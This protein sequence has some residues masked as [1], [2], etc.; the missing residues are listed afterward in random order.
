MTPGFSR[1]ISLPLSPSRKKPSHVRSASLPCRSH[2]LVSHLEDEIRAVRSWL[3]HP[4][5]DPGSPAGIQAGLAQIQYLHAALDDLLHLPRAQDPL[6]RAAG[7]D[8][9]LD[10][11]LRLA[12][13]YG[14]FRSA[15]VALKQHASEAQAAIRRRDA[16]RLASAVRSVRRSEKELSKLASTVRSAGRCSAPGLA[17]V[18]AEAEIAGI[19]RE[20]IGAT[21]AASASV[22]TGVA[23]ISAAARVSCGVGLWK[24]VDLMFEF[25]KKASKEEKE[26]MALD[27]LEK[28][29][30]CVLNLESGNEQVFR[31]LV[32]T[33]VSLLNI[34]TPTF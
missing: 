10:T 27:K 11:F 15:A 8:R 13:A 6:R 30:E 7:G 5:P 25:K 34:L 14:S 9:L 33:R 3:S 18:S 24:K 21:V 20:A 1:S 17:S 12:D 2:P 29:E 16:A 32:N 31:S 19:V 26:M 22:F 23:E 4:D 28:L